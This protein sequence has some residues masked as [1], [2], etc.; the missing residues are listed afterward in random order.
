MNIPKELENISNA[1]VITTDTEQEKAADI[2]TKALH[3]QDTVVAEKEKLT[4]PLNEALKEIRGRYKPVEDR[5]NT[6][7]STLRTGIGSYQM[8]KLA[9]AKRIAEEKAQQV[10]SGE[11]SIDDA[12]GDEGGDMEIS[13]SIKTVAG[14]VS[15]RKVQK[16][17]ITDA[18]KIPRTYLIPDEKKIIE[19]LKAGKSIAGCC[20]IE[21][22]QVVGKR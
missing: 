3:F 14:S 18:S 16:L 7:I 21:V 15:F 12:I 9:E 22:Q 13:G 19:G 4:K 1:G 17:E 5:L 8:H 10:V 20:L 11:L 2:L 6:I